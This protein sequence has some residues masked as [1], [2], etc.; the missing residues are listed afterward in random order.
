MPLVEDCRS[1]PLEVTPRGNE[2]A[3]RTIRRFIKLVKL[4]GVMKESSRRSWFEKPSA[5]RRRKIAQ[6]R[7]NVRSRERERKNE[8][9][10]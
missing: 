6:G 7:A 9:A 10:R 2:P 8:G 3:E 5:K 1:V 4:D